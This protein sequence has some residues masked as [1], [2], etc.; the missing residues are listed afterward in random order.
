MSTSVFTNGIGYVTS[1]MSSSPVA[2]SGPALA[3][4]AQATA[5]LLEIEGDH[6]EAPERDAEQDDGDQV[7]GL[8]FPEPGLRPAKGRTACKV[9]PPGR[10][11]RDERHGEEPHQQ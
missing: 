4:A 10:D 11:D 8:E 7:T 1:S 5:M 6:D 9:Q 3:L 2:S